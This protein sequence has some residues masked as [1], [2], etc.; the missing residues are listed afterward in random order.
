VLLPAGTFQLLGNIVVRA[1]ES[2]KMQGDGALQASLALGRWQL[3]VEAGGRLELLG[4]AVVDA[5]GSSAMVVLGEVMAT[6]CTFSRCVSGPNLLLRNAEE[7]SLEGSDEHPPVQ[8][9]YVGSVGAVAFLA[10]TPAKFTAHGCTFSENRASGARLFN[11]GGAINTLGGSLVLCSGTIMR[12]NVAEGGAMASRG[13]AIYSTYSQIDISDVMFVGNEANGGSGGTDTVNVRRDTNRLAQVVRGGA[14]DFTNCRVTISSTT[15]KQ[16]RAQDASVRAAGGAL[17][18][19]EGSVVE[20]TRCWFDRN[21][22]L[23]G[24]QVTNGG[25][26]RVDAGGSFRAVD[27]NFDGN[28]VEAPAEGFGGAIATE[29]S[30]AL[31]GGVV[32]RG[33]IVYGDVRAA[34]GAI[35]VLSATASFNASELPG[36]VFVGNAVRLF[37]RPV[38]QLPAKAKSAFGIHYRRFSARIRNGLMQGKGTRPLGGAVY[39]EAAGTAPLVSAL[40]ESNSVLVRPVRSRRSCDRHRFA[41]CSCRLSALVGMAVPCT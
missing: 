37:P 10:L 16:N 15:F 30:L 8:G 38:S 26:L 39:F 25:A 9:A 29:G 13:G 12:D 7:I 24:G 34:G 19:G 23:R 5:V 11:S 40:F 41:S 22:A 31:G 28:A 18:L 2:L 14:A 20:A 6:N 1:G 3:V 32:F 4:L 21:T 17:A 33:N 36:P 27:T 35:A